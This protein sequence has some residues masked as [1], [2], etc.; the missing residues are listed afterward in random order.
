MHQAYVSSTLLS[1]RSK[2]SLSFSFNDCSNLL[3]ERFERSPL[4]SCPAQC[5]SCCSC[6]SCCCVS[7]FG[8]PRVPISSGW[9]YGLRQSTLI[10]RPPYRRLV[11]GAGDRYS[12]RVPAYGLD[13]DCSQVSYSIQGN[14]G[15]NGIRRSSEKRLGRISSWERRCSSNADDVEAMI[16]LLSEELGEEYLGDRER[17]K[18]LSKRVEIKDR[19]NYRGDH[20]RK[21]K[22]VRLGLLESDSKCK[23]ES[24]IVKSRNEQ[25][26]GNKVDDKTE[27]VEE[28]TAVANNE[29]LK[30]RR[31]SISSYYSLSGEDFDSDT[32]S[33][34]EHCDVVK[35]ASVICRRDLKNEDGRFE[36]CTV[37]EFKRHR[38]GIEG[39][40]GVLGC[41]TGVTNTNFDWDVRKKSEKKLT[42]IDET[43]LRK[44]SS[45]VQSITAPS[46]AK[47]FNDE[48][49]TTDLFSYLQK[50]RKKNYSQMDN[51]SVEQAKI[52]RNYQEVT[53]SEDKYARHVEAASHHQKHEDLLQRRR[54]ENH[55]TVGRSSTNDSL[56]KNTQH[57]AEISEI[58][59]VDV[60][61]DS[62][63][64]KWSESQVK[65][66]E[67]DIDIK[68]SRN[69]SEQLD[70]RGDQTT[71]KILTRRSESSRRKEL[72]DSAII[73]KSSAEEEHSSNDKTTLQRIRSRKGSQGVQNISV[74]VT[75]VSVLQ[76][77][78][79][80]TVTNNLSISDDVLINQGSKSTSVVKPFVEIGKKNQTDESA[81]DVKSQKE[82][83][84]AD[85]VLSYSEGTSHEAATSQVS[86]DRVSEMRMQ[87]TNVQEHDEDVQKSSNPVMIPPTHQL[88]A[89]GPLLLDPTGEVAKQDSSTETFESSSSAFYTSSGGRTPA[90]HKSEDNRG[91]SS[92]AYGEPLN[93]VAHEDT[94]DSAYRLEESS[95]IYVDDF[96]QQSKHEL[97]TPGIQE[98]MTMSVTKV[99]SESEK[100]RQKKS[101]HDF[102]KDS[103][104]TDQDSGPS[105]GSSG[106]KGPSDEMWD[107][108]DTTT[109]ESLEKEEAEDNT[110]TETLA[111][112][113][114]GRSL[115]GI[116]ANIVRLRWGSHAEM[117]KPAVNS[118]TK[119]SSND[120][121]SSE[122]Y[123][124][125]HD[126]EVNSDWNGKKERSMPK[127]LTSSLQ[128]QLRQTS[129]Q[130]QEEILDT[131]AT[132]GITRQLE[133]ETSSHSGISKNGLTSK[134][135]SSPEHEEHVG[136]SLD[137]KGFQVG[138]SNMEG[139][140]SSLVPVPFSYHGT[141]S[142]IVEERFDSGKSNASD[143]GLM[144]P[145]KQHVSGKLHEV[146]GRDG[147]DGELKLKK[148]Q[149]NK[150]VIR[151][152]FDEWEEAYL[153]ESEQRKSDEIFMREALLEAKHAADTWEVP[154]GAV[155]VQHGKIIARGYNL[156]EEL[157]DSTAHAEMICIREA[158]KQLRSWRLS[159]ATLYVT[160]EP[161]A[162]CAGAILQARIDTLVWGAPNKLLGA[163][164]S[165]ISLFPNGEEN[166]NGGQPTDKPAAPVHPF[167]P[168]MTIRRG[169]LESQCAEVMQQFFQL[170]RRK[171]QKNEDEPPQPTCLPVA[172]SQSKVLDKLHNIFHVMFCL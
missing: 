65:V 48:K 86:L 162:M 59:N 75:N 37:E 115:W 129:G 45:E 71:Q 76:A 119:S 111:V 58:G 57:M 150:Q 62:N 98:E 147:K 13:L 141:T 27:G 155:L 74:N 125:G 157:R 38:D 148:L 158:S 66:Q 81:F 53:E 85:K 132:K 167:H 149:R 118:G 46:S 20:R 114:T 153:R 159:D 51:E 17:K 44:E 68:K 163:D 152:R 160:L 50:E 107:V 91:V 21:K 34:D 131:S 29:N 164:G 168:K 108:R 11:L 93:L 4:L 100:R 16:S 104:L 87:Q 31:D 5:C 36:G 70:Q 33:Q 127:E 22:D 139:G 145:A 26:S 40:S 121:V 126:H 25:F 6:C 18:S 54:A 15:S 23:F 169:V 55:K 144:Q 80:K 172:S 19:G 39:K 134:G 136:F 142:H 49:E 106:V 109:Q 83:Y 133:L 113:R 166:R 47:K 90:Q 120:S 84:R 8:S 122:A 61:R 137:Q 89:R 56:R 92:V 102:T 112:R 95:R 64:Q 151:D 156:V 28:N 117:P 24:V 14:S 143:S 138:S 146:L 130:G 154:V 10:Q 77:I 170:R 42:E 110:A 3:N 99:D 79:S 165:W 52:R 94:L 140:K 96:I 30:G 32:E 73:T 63:L 116:I 123:F 82:T 1:F 97:S 103:Q 9:L 35:K 60:H 88:V 7:S 128:L 161:C 43:Q 67:E 78:D 101:S 135:I 105:L 2:G 41:R 69:A 171:K 72:G 12:Y 124:S